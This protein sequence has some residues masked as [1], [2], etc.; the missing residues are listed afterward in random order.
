MPPPSQF[1]HHRPKTRP[2]TIYQSQRRPP[3]LSRSASGDLHFDPCSIDT[4]SCH[5]DANIVLLSNL[6]NGKV[7]AEGIEKQSTRQEQRTSK[8]RRFGFLF[9]IACKKVV[10]SQLLHLPQ[11][12]LEDE[13][14]K[15]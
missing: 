10:A 1:L 12:V 6:L 14:G 2:Y 5:L 4:E 7:R 8:P 11:I 3:V 9:W 13:M 15:L